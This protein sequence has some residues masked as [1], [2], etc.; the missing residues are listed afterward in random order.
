[1]EGLEKSFEFTYGNLKQGFISKVMAEYLTGFVDL[2][3]A[4]TA[5]TPLTLLIHCSK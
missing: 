2:D 4:T 5:T 3:D 1:M